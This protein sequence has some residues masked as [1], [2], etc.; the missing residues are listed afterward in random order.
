MKF[1][2]KEKD[3]AVEYFNDVPWWLTEVV[4]S[5]E[6]VPG[7]VWGLSSKGEILPAIFI[8][9][10]VLAICGVI[11]Q[12]LFGAWVSVAVV[13]VMVVIMILWPLYKYK[14]GRGYE[15]D[16]RYD[17]AG[18]YITTM[19]TNGFINTTVLVKKYGPLKLSNHMNSFYRLAE[20]GEER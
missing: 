6:G 1:S 15:V 5:E 11:S 2:H 18:E 9:A 13:A 16:K 7:G 14:N 10:C 4:S 8:P 12:A 17:S 19:K 3:K 20:V